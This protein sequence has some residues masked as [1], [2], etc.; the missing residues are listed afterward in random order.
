[1]L[2]RISLALIFLFKKDILNTNC[3]DLPNYLKSFVRENIDKL[4]TKELFKVTLS[5]KVTNRLLKVLEILHDHSSPSH[6][7]LT[8]QPNTKLDWKILP[9]DF[10]SAAAD[11]SMIQ[12]E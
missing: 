11:P 8:S 6:V 9:E 1:M 2:I 3:D 7:I 4:E 12:T 5:F 10:T